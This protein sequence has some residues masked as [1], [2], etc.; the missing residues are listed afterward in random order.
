MRGGGRGESEEREEKDATE[1]KMSSDIVAKEQHLVNKDNVHTVSIQLAY[2]INTN[3]ENVTL[4]DKNC[5]NNDHSVNVLP[6]AAQ[7]STTKQIQIIQIYVFFFS[8]LFSKA[9]V[10]HLAL[11]KAQNILQLKNVPLGLPYL[12]LI[13]KSLHGSIGCLA[14]FL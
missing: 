8:S 13:S 5:P 2:I 11:L 1:P 7:P 3:Q 9:I 12:C 6:L 10:W 4:Q 14:G